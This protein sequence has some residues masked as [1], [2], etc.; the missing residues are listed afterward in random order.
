M[1]YF[2]VLISL[3]KIEIF[4]SYMSFHLFIENKSVK[5]IAISKKLKFLIFE[6]KCI[7]LLL[8]FEYKCN[9]NLTFLFANWICLRIFD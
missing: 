1:Q 6:S 3:K 2:E 7:H 9:E 4:Q 8:C 5:N